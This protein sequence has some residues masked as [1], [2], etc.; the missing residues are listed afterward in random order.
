M[1]VMD[2]FMN[3]DIKYDDNGR[4]LQVIYSYK[5]IRFLVPTFT[6]ANILEHIV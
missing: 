6:L 3:G 5:I 2:V 4:V 1:F